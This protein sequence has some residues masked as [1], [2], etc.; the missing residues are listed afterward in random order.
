MRVL[1]TGASG[2]VGR[3][4]LVTLRDRSHEVIAAKSLLHPGKTGWCRLSGTFESTQVPTEMRL[5]CG[6][7]IF[8]TWR[9][10]GNVEAEYFCDRAPVILEFLEADALPL[11]PVAVLCNELALSAAGWAGSAVLAATQSGKGM[12]AIT[13]RAESP[14]KN[15]KNFLTTDAQRLII[16]SSP[17]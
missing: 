11:R 15:I 10:G 3:G 4:L 5:R 1:V 2:F 9:V 16:I 8:G 14:E 6:N 7:R 12:S 17:R 13:N